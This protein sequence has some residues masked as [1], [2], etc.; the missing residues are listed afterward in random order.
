M[1]ALYQLPKIPQTDAGVSYLI[2]RLQEPLET[3]VKI[4]FIAPGKWTGPTL[5]SLNTNDFLSRG[6]LIL[7]ESVNDQAQA[8][9]EARKA[10]PIYIPIKLAGAIHSIAIGVYVNR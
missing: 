4:G 9:R 7:S 1:D 10:P 3:A 8:D 6:Y 2:T 5:L